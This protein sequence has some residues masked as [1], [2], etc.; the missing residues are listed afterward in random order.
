[1]SHASL[2]RLQ[3]DTSLPDKGRFEARSLPRGLG[4]RKMLARR[5]RGAIFVEAI[6]VCSMLMTMLAGAIFFHSMYSAKILALREARLAAW[7]VAEEGCASSMG[8]GQLFSLVADGDCADDNC[9][10]GGLDLQSDDKPSWLDTGAETSEITHTVSAH[11]R[12]GGRTHSMKAYNRVICNE[13]RQNARGDL[14]SIG[15]YI[16]DAVIP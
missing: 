8:V 1:M 4:R 7:Q 15:E 16:F 12:A 3:A 2:A 5:Q 10:L 11:A 9:S 14:A 13:Q 6:I